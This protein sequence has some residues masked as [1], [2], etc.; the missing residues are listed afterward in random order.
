MQGERFRPQFAGNVGHNAD[1]IAFAIDEA[2]T[3]SHTGE[4]FDRAFD[5]A[6]CGLT[7][8]TDGAN[9]GAGIALAGIFPVKNVGI[10]SELDIAL[11]LH[12]TLDYD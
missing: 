2:G 4:G 10:K 1:A 11:L 3:V 7:A 12:S 5:V 8:L 9:Q 6:V